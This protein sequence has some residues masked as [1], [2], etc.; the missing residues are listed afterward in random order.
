MKKQGSMRKKA[1]WKNK[2]KR[3]KKNRRDMVLRQIRG[4]TREWETLRQRKKGKKKKK[5]YMKVMNLTFSKITLK[6]IK[7]IAEYESEYE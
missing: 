6:M 2:D 3:E 7:K 1:L 5:S 4:K